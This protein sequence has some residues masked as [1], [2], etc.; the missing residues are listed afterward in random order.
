MVGG[1]ACCTTAVATLLI[2]DPC[3]KPS[4][5]TSSAVTIPRLSPKRAQLDS[6]PGYDEINLTWLPKRGRSAEGAFGA[7]L[8]AGCPICPACVEAD[9]QGPLR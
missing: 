6:G 3:E 8:M 9:A 4:P 1:A 5:S 2:S 7:C